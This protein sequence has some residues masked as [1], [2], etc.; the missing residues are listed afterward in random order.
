MVD[1]ENRESFG[2][3][4]GVEGVERDEAEGEGILYPDSTYRPSLISQS[5]L[6]LVREYNYS[7]LCSSNHLNE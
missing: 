4:K 3:R 6:S 1:R 7:L 2:G 5:V